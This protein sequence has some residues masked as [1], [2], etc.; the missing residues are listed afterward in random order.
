LAFH[1]E[2]ALLLAAERVAARPGTK[3]KSQIMAV[4]ESHGFDFAHDLEDLLIGVFPPEA[5][6]NDECDYR[7][8]FVQTCT[9]GRRSRARSLEIRCFFVYRMGVD[10]IYP[11]WLFSTSINAGLVSAGL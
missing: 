3:S 7:H 1:G 10:K 11:E 4:I 9:D 5:C 6:G 2:A 8:L